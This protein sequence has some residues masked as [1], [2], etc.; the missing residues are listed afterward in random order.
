[1]LKIAID[2]AC[3]RNGKPD[4]VSAGGVF[5]RYA[6]DNQTVSKIE[7]ETKAVCEFNSTNQ[8]G[9][10]LALLTALEHI[11]T[12]QT[13]AQIVTD[14]EYIF[15]AM[16]KLWYVRWRNSRWLTAIGEPVK[17][18]DL[19][20]KIDEVACWC[21]AYGLEID[22][23]HIKGHV[24][25][26]G[27]VTAGKLL[28]QDC[29]GE[30]LYHEVCQKYNLVGPSRKEKLSAA[31]DLSLKN[32]GFYLPVDVFKDFVVS[33]IVVDAV[34]TAEVEAANSALMLERL[35]K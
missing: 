28:L 11:R 29:T 20:K 8:R 3:R 19:W 10:L 24:I 15:N 12:M 1:M 34:A 9:E 14:S 23:Y 13:Y 25:P 22:Y 5:I 16:T 7:F 26:F 18:A 17:N 32:N 6:D 2:G 27:E 30:K 31:Q 33:N 21:E 4:C 35:K